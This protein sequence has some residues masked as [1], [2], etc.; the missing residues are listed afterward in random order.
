MSYIINI[1][2]IG[3]CLLSDQSNGALAGLLLAY[4]FTIDGNVTNLIYSLSNL[5]TKMISVE[6][7]SKFMSI[8]PEAGYVEYTKKWNTRD[9]PAN[10]I[11][12][13]G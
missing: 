2:A 12:N 3:Y 6:R 13:K 1:S 8:E 9:E 5:E 10:I 4:A 7:I 11:V